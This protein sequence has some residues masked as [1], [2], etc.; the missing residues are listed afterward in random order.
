MLKCHNLLFLFIFVV[1]CS[2]I[3]TKLGMYRCLFWH[4]NKTGDV[5]LVVLSSK[6]NWGCTVVCSGIETKLGMYRCLFWHR[7]KIGDIRLVVLASKQNW[8]C[9]AGCSGIDTKLG[10]Y[11]CLFWLRNK[12]GDVPLLVLA[13]KENKNALF[14]G[15]KVEFLTLILTVHKMTRETRGDKRLCI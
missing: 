14:L 3:E 9:T 6:Q 10:M 11:R 13:S 15:Q 7:N 4:R 8:G 1:K 5:P 2:G 12:T